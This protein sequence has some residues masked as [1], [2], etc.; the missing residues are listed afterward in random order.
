MRRSFEATVS[1]L[2]YSIVE[3][4]CAPVAADRFPHN[5]AVRFVLGQC[6]RM[7]DWLRLPFRCL[8]LGF[9]VCGIANGGRR[10]HRQLPASRAKQIERWRQSRWAV[11]RDFMR[12]FDSL[13]LL[14]WNSQS[15]VSN[16]ARMDLERSSADAPPREH[17]VTG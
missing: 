7:P 9:D 3:S 5:D 6:E 14:W 11:C 1:A 2:C 10:F 13:V 8:T 12:F 15:H 17:A 4:R 16:D